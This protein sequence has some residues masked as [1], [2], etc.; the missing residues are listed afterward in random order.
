MTYV[1]AETRKDEKCESKTSREGR[2]KNTKCKNDEGSGDQSSQTGQVF[3]AS[4]G[5]RRIDTGSVMDAGDNALSSIPV[6]STGPNNAAHPVIHSL[7]PLY[8]YS[9]LR[10]LV[11][12]ASLATSLINVIT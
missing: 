8:I 7:P 3:G 10:D 5:K 12:L 6:R 1:T 4:C 2:T 9:F 11:L